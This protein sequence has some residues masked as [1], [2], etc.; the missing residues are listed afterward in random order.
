MYRKENISK[1]RLV[2]NLKIS[3]REHT[4][5]KV[6]KEQFKTYIKIDFREVPAVVKNLFLNN[7]K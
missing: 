5:E 7:F 2:Y 4:S 6:C 3:T 1:H